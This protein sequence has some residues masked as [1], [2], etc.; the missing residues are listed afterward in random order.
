M[1]VMRITR[2]FELDSSRQGDPRFDSKSC[3]SFFKGN[4]TANRAVEIFIH[5]TVERILCMRLERCTGIH[6]FP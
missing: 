4:V 3:I 2:G 1:S 5:N 6:V